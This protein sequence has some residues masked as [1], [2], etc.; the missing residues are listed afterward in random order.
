MKGEHDEDNCN[1]LD[2][3]MVGA[4]IEITDEAGMPLFARLTINPA[5]NFYTTRSVP[6]TF[7]VKLF[8]QGREIAM[9]EPVTNGDCNYCHR[10]DDFMQTKGRIVPPPP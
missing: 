4:A 3:T 1:G 6:G 5:G 2:S 7:K 10:K 9:K 8:S